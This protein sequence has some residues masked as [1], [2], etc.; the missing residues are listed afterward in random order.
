MVTREPSGAAAFLPTMKP[1]ARTISSTDCSTTGPGLV[2][3]PVHGVADILFVH[4]AV[5][6]PDLHE[7]PVVGLADRGV[8]AGAEKSSSPMASS[9][10]FRA[11]STSASRASTSPPGLRGQGH[12]PPLVEP[13]MSLRT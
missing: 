4:P 11:A 12:D 10:C 8:Q 9:A 5:E 6:H 2:P 13:P 7:P 1:R 3:G